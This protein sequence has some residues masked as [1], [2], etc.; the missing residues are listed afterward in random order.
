MDT[1]WLEDFISLAETRSFSKSATQRHVSQPAFSRRIR[2]LE[3]W[4]GTDLIDRTS[5]PT[6]LTPAGEV[7]YEQ[8]LEML[9]QINTARELMRDRRGAEPVSEAL[10]LRLVK[11]EQAPEPVASVAAA[12]TTASAARPVGRGPFS[13]PPE[14]VAEED[15][16][17]LMGLLKLEMG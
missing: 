6:K 14:P 11:Q 10:P 15:P 13:A 7:F 5:Y 2:S 17:L 8:A 3:T 12:T 16:E 9:A 1:R 4:L